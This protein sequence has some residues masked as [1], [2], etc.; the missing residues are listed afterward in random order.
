MVKSMLM[1]WNADA[2]KWARNASVHYKA[3]M[4]KK[5]ED[6]NYVNPWGEKDELPKMKPVQTMIEQCQCQRTVNASEVIDVNTVN[7]NDST[8][9]KH[10]VYRGKGQRVIILIFL[11]L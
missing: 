8:C 10:S 9:S 4:E 7:F 11:F 3:A 5:W 6:P 2:S 1:L